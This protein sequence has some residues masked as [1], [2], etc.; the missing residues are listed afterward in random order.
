MLAIDHYFVI[1][2][3]FSISHTL[4]VWPEISVWLLAN[5]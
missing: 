5:S 2:G 4:P 3:L 1:I